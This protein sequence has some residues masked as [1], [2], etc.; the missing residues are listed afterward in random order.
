MRRRPPLT[1][2]TLDGLRYSLDVERHDERTTAAG[3]QIDDYAQPLPPERPG[4]PEAGG[5]W[6]TAVDVV[7]GY[8]FAD[9]GLIRATWAPGAPLQD[10]SML[11]EARFLGLRFPVGTR[12]YRV[13]DER[14]VDADGSEVRARGWGYA[15]LTGHFEMGTMDYE[16][17]KRLADGAVEF[18]VHVVSRRAPVRNPLIRIGFR[19]F[20][21]RLQRRFARNACRRV[22]TLVGE[23][24]AVT[25]DAVATAR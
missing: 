21:R 10:R 24:A 25:A 3:W 19:L 4:E 20:G 23:R 7:E 8:E 12:V 2:E 14:R 17:R 11:L 6:Q 16:V 13:V 5:A 15:T 9:P 18:R 22:A 1:L